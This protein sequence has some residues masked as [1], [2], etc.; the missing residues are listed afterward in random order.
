MKKIAGYEVEAELWRGA[1]GIVYKAL[2]HSL[3]HRVA[4]KILP[5][6]LKEHPDLVTRFKR[7]AMVAASLNHPN[8]VTV[9][10]IGEEDGH[11]FIAMEM[12]EG[13]NLAE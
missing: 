5:A 10:A 12:V 4:L 7:E 11:Y 1:M 13:Q 3:G 2:D 6:H 8:M 9:C